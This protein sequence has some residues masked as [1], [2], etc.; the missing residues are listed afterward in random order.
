MGRGTADLGRV[1]EDLFR[2]LR[3]HNYG[4]DFHL[5]PIMSTDERVSAIDFFNQPGLPWRASSTGGFLHFLLDR[6]FRYFSG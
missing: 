6:A 2:L 5:R 3:I 1:P 4:Q